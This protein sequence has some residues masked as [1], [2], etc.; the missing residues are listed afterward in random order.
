MTVEEFRKKGVA[1]V[2]TCCCCCCTMPLCMTLIAWDDA[3]VINSVNEPQCM[4][5]RAAM[6]RLVA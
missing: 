6:H 1:R 4:T 5:G 2:T 3:G